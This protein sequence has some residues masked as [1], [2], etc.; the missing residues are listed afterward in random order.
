MG[1]WPTLVCLSL[2]EFSSAAGQDRHSPS[3]P[4][5]AAASKSTIDNVEHVYLTTVT[6][7]LYEIEV[8]RKHAG[9]ADHNPQWDYALAW[10]IENS[11]LNHD[12][13][14][15]LAAEPD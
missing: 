15:P 2:W 11:L 7:G 6:A 12:P 4:A 9:I 14:S 1:N 10:W 5:L 13:P 8:R 3:T